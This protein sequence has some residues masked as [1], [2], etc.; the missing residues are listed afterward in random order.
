MATIL[1]QTRCDGGGSGGGG[2]GGGGGV[3]GLLTNSH[4]TNSGVCWLEDRFL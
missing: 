4:P 3:C 1:E 2:G